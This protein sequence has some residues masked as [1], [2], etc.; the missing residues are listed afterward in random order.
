MNYVDCSNYAP[1]ACLDSCLNCGYTKARHNFNLEERPKKTMDTRTFPEIVY[2]TLDCTEEL[3]KEF[4]KI[5]LEDIKVF[6]KKQSD[7]GSKNISEFGEHGVLVR[8]ND[9]MS[10]LKKLLKYQQAGGYK[11]SSNESI[12]DSWLDL[13]NYSVIARMCRKGVWPL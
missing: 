1:H 11:E 6:D 2:E 4:I 12:G 7:Y 3:T 5:V 10:R 13:S 8:C 9:K